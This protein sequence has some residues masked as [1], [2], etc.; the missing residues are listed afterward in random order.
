MP[1]HEGSGGNAG[2]RGARRSSA[3]SL[4]K[5]RASEL[6]FRKRPRYFTLP[7]ESFQATFVTITAHTARSSVSGR[8]NCC[9]APA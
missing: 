3:R 2:A 8:R 4:L 9:F 1:R 5:S 6:L 7:H